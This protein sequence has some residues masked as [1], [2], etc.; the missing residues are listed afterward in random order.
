MAALSESKRDGGAPVELGEEENHVEF[1]LDAPNG[2]LQ[3][4]VTD[5]ELEN[6]VRI[7]AP[8]LEVS[9]QIAG[10]GEKLTLQP[11]AN[12][13]TGEKVGDTSLFEVEADWLKM[14]PTFDAVLKE[15]TV[16]GKTYTNISFNFPKGNDESKK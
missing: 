3:A 16:N 7:D 5:G 15:I 10:R 13:A 4:F 12:D 2:R 9:G 1:V 11:I 6:F 8:S 14:T